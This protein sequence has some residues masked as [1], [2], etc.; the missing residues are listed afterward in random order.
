MLYCLAIYTGMRRE[1]ILGL[2]W[3][4]INFER[5][6]FMSNILFIIYPLKG[7]FYKLLKQSV[8]KDNFHYR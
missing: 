6:E 3:K 2:R 5:K 7:L 1:E 4:D 8:V